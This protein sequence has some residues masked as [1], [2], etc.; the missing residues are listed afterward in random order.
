L[1]ADD[2]SARLAAPLSRV[3]RRNQLEEGAAG[4]CPNCPLG[5]ELASL[6]LLALLLARGGRQP[7]QLGQHGL[8]AGNLVPGPAEAGAVESPHLLLQIGNP[9]RRWSRRGMAEQY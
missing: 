2:F 5:V 4:E 3:D 7:L 6:L 9:A 8:G 1:L